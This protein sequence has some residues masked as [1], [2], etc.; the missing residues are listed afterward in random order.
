[1]QIQP[2]WVLFDQGL[3]VVVWVYLMGM[4]SNI[5]TRRLD[6]TQSV[7]WVTYIIQMIC[8]NPPPKKN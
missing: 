3:T 2:Y 1:M 6:I 7:Q 8:N 4:L 5:H